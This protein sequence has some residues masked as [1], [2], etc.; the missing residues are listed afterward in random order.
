MCTIFVTLIT[1]EQHDDN[2]IGKKL[3]IS[4]EH[5]SGSTKNSGGIVLTDHL[6]ELFGNIS[7]VCEEQFELIRKIFPFNT[8]AKVTRQLIQRIFCDPAFGIQARVDMVL[9]PKPPREPLTLPD[10]LDALTTVREKLSALYVMLLD[11]CV[12]P[13]LR[14]MGNEYNEYGGPQSMGF[15]DSRS[16]GSTEESDFQDLKNEEYEKN[17]S[18]TEIKDFLLEQISQ[19]LGA[20]VTDYFDKEITHMKLCYLE[21]LRKAAGDDP[22][23]LT[24][25]AIL[26]APLPKL[27]AER[28]K[29]IENIV[30][31]IAN[32]KYLTS[33][34]N[35][36][37]DSV[38]RMESIGKTDVKRLH[39]KIENLYRLQLG[40]V[41]DSLMVPWSQAC[42]TMLLKSASAK[43]QV[44]AYI[45][46][47]I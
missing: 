35:I 43:P 16:P 44:K 4:T 21:G 2:L 24:K 46:I 47:Y 37:T 32:K 18:E 1:S 29:S 6:S 22:Q 8:I 13:A 17:K 14:G 26:Q 40:F 34:F 28:M 27:K 39:L 7:L 33:I 9:V 41:V 12:H 10:Y 45:Y 30:K 38:L 3:V 31:T 15:S 20:Y 19:V 23:L 36:T 11:S 5:S 25:V 42:T